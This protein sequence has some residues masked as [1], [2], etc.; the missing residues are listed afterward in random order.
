[1]TMAKFG[2]LGTWDDSWGIV[3]A[4]LENKEYSLVPDLKYAKP[5]PVFVT[6]LDD[7]VKAM[8]LDRANGFLWST[9]FSVYPP[10]MESIEAG[11]NAGKYY[12]SLTSGGPYL[13]LV[14]PGCYQEGGVI[15]LVPGALYSPNWT[16]KPGTYIAIKPSPELRAGFKEVKAIIQ[17]QLVRLKGGPYNWIGRDASRLL[18]ERRARIPG[19]EVPGAAAQ[20]DPEGGSP[21]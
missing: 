19:L 10:S 9:K 18:E 15:N 11:Q 16:T 7:T 8:F 1:M 17:R 12:V 2:F 14:L 3:A 13:R 5:E 6:K 20:A 21:T 4:I